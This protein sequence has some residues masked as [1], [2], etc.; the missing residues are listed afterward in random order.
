MGAP[1]QGHGRGESME[2]GWWGR[3]G[4]SG[5]EGAEGM[6]EARGFPIPTAVC[7]A[8][9]NRGDGR[10]ERKRKGMT[11]RVGALVR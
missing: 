4:D 10:T 7:Y 1:G 8:R 11:G 5:R 3:S 6:R 2:G 9:P